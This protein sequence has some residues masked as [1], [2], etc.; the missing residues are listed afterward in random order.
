[1][2]DGWDAAMKGEMLPLCAIRTAL[3]T[4]RKWK[5]E[6]AHME[7]PLLHLQDSGPYIKESRKYNTC[8]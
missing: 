5:V 7:A 8:W 2:I 6:C 1:M 4:L 3:T